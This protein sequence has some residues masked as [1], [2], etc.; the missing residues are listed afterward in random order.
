[1]DIGAVEIGGFYD[2]LGA[3]ISRESS[4]VK[5]KGVEVRRVI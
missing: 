5:E 1:M 4:P 3:F 2:P